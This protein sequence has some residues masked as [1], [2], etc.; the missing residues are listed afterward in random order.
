[1]FRKLPYAPPLLMGLEAE[2]GFSL[3]CPGLAQS[4]AAVAVLIFFSG[5]G[6]E[7]TSGLGKL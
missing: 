3:L 1:M 7:R 5:L 4:A 2:F 6:L